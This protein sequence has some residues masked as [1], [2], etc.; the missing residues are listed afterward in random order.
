MIRRPPRS[1]LFPY[2]TLFRSVRERL[3]AP[4]VYLISPKWTFSATLRVSRSCKVVAGPRLA[5]SVQERSAQTSFFAGVNSSACT[6]VFAGST[7]LLH[8]L[9]QLLTRVLPLGRRVAIWKP[10]IL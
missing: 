7:V 2:T 4:H 1:T 8:W 9:T 6:G 3:P 10:A 5:G